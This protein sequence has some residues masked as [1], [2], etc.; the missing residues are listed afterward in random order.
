LLLLVLGVGAQA[1]VVRVAA[2]AS[3]TL[4]LTEAARGFEEATGIEVRL[5]FGASGALAR[6]IE[7]GLPVDLF[8][9]ANPD[10][11][12]YL[13]ERGRIEEESVRPVVRNRLVVVVPEGSALTLESPGDLVRAGRIAVGDPAVVPAGRYAMQA[14]ASL[15]LE[16]KLAD[17]LLPAANVRAALAYVARNEVDAGFVY[18]TDGLADPRVR[19]ALELDSSLHDPILYPAAR[20]ADAQAPAP[21]DRFLEDLLSGAGAALL[22]DA[23][24]LPPSDPP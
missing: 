21:A 4:P 1:D 16:D 6:Q 17:R 20:V 19:I 18:R 2:A 10:W 5:S 3:L 14:L 9:S 8:L 23:G 7:H 11:M 22:R 24:F 13:E 12:T 15:G